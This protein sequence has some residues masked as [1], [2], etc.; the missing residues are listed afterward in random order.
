MAFAA[1]DL[2]RGMSSHAIG[3]DVES[4]SVID[5]EGVL[6]GRT[7]PTEVG[8]GMSSSPKGGAGIDV[9]NGLQF[10]GGSGV[11]RRW[12]PGRSSVIAGRHSKDPSEVYREPVRLNDTNFAC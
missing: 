8:Q 1:R 10:R 6:V 11:E 2:S 4:Q 3:D 12:P 9:V 5:Q 7:F